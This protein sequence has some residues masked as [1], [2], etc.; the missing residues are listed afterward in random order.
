MKILIA[1]DDFT[2]R[3][4][5][6]AVLKKR[7]HE[8]VET[9]NGLEAWETMQQ[10]DTPRMA[11]LDWMMPGMDG[12]EVCRNIRTL[13]TDQPPYVIMLTSKL[14]T[15]DVV[16]GLEA[17]ADD[18][19]AK[20]YA[21]TELHARVEVG[22]RMIEIQAQ[23]AGKI[24]ELES[25]HQ[26]LQRS[27]DIASKV[28][29]K[30]MQSNERRCGNVKYLLSSMETASGD[31]ALSVPKPSGGI[32]A[33]LG[34][35]TGHGLSAAIG[36]V[37]VADI[38]LAMTD[39]NY[40]IC[41]IAAEM[42]AKLRETLP[43]GMYLAACLLELEFSSGTL[44]VWNGGIPDVLVVGRQ[45][46]IKNRLS[47]SHLPL[48]VISNDELDLSVDLIEIEQDDHIYVYSDG[49]TEACN[50][51]NEMFGQQR[52]EELLGQGPLPE[53][54]LETINTSLETYR[55][56]TSQD[57]DTTMIEIICNAEAAGNFLDGDPAINRETAGG[58][59][60]S[61]QFEA[62]SLRNVD[63]ASYLIKII[64]EDRELRPHKVNVFLIITELVTN[65]L[66]YGLFRL[67]PGLKKSLEDYERYIEA[68]QKGFESISDGW[69]RIGLE[70]APLA[71]GG[72]LVVQV[73]DSGPGF[74]Y[75]KN[76]LALADNLT[77]SGRG[78]PLVRS[79][80]SD[81]T[82]HGR[83]NRVKAVYQWT[84]ESS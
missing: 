81:F 79:L 31:I 20:P 3:I 66:D 65:A 28:F 70:Y 51:D 53:S 8:V 2:S 48:G 58:W 49:V 23:L 27:Y 15:E 18:Y 69:L 43:I 72:K 34:D 12:V 22:R 37:P 32:Y 9:T 54:A 17:G 83:G 14:E 55:A 46:G 77:Y 76:F 10:P 50:P 38:F 80:C 25:L 5:L 84:E 61:L 30:I 68:R 1:E 24:S 21:A 11:I 47:S 39:R 82:Y 42:N 63:I 19:I 44:T 16:A 41:D 62:D 60:L 67:G 52:L 35:F 75:Q 26:E 57:D 45:G 59:N 33:F 64:E 7:G 73:E 40:S 13:K 71:E 56:G 4:M 78:L 74:N 6:A 29:S 36:A